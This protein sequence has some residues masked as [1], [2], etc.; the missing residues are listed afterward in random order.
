MYLLLDNRIFKLSILLFP[1]FARMAPGHLAGGQS[2]DKQISTETE[3]D[4]QTQ[5]ENRQ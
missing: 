3:G 1:R 5:T 2:V 4:Y